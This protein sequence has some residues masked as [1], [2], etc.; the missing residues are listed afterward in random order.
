[1]AVKRCGD[2]SMDEGGRWQHPYSCRTSARQVSQLLTHNFRAITRRVLR[3]LRIDPQTRRRTNNRI[4]SEDG[5]ETSAEEYKRINKGLAM[6][7]LSSCL[8]TCLDSPS[9]VHSACVL[10]EN[11]YP[12]TFAQGGDRG[13]DIVSTYG[14]HFRIVAEVSAKRHRF[15]DFFEDQMTRAIKHAKNE[16]KAD[17]KRPIYVL[18]VNVCSIEQGKGYWDTYKALEPT[19]REAGD[20]KVVP[21]WG[22]DFAELVS[23]LCEPTRVTGLDF[24]PLEFAEV[25]DYVHAR[26][27]SGDD[28]PEPGWTRRTLHGG[29][30]NPLSLELAVPEGDEADN[31][32][33]PEP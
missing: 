29:I 23:S 25:L 17:P 14:E 33:D 15:P 8:L 27:A 18:L 12:K 16:W 31:T 22:R 26:L 9:D 6:E 20:I 13:S 3:P 19:A 10:N 2:V 24:G 11:G 5:T 32:D 1:M 30:E 7:L 4:F 28:P 21:I